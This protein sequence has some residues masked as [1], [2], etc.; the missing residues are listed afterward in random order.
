VL[1]LVLA[2]GAFA[3]V[4]SARKA[5]KHKVSA[6]IQLATIT[7]DSKFPAIGSSS[8]DAGIVKATPGGRGAE[9]DTLKVTAM[10]AAGQLTLSGTAKLF[11]VKGTQTAK[12]T[13][14]AVVA[15]DGSVTYTGTGQFTKG[16]GTYKGITGNV[17]FT[18]SSPAGSS[19]VSLQVKGTARY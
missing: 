10:P 5:T 2:I 1:V 14:Q 19:V 16:T 7:Q 17:T 4:A 3:A 11:F 13:V 6:T 9:T 12:L 8:T 15:A 18:G